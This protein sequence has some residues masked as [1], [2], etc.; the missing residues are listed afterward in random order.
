MEKPI[1][2]ALMI[3]VGVI[4][5]VLVFDAVYPATIQSSSAITS[6][7]GRID[8]RLKSQIEIIH[9]TGELDSSGTWQ[10]TNGDGDFDV[11][12]WVKN[13]GSSRITAIERCDIFF[14]KE[15]DFSRIPYVDESGGTY[16]YWE[17]TLEND[18]DWDPTATLKVDINYSSTLTSGMYFLK[19]VILNGISDSYYFSMGN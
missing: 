13:V 15:G 11:F 1:V 8:D 6:M 18:N 19:V 3:M 10:D 5:A 12:A 2:T 16:P 7:R 17:W 4:G 9:A 14:G